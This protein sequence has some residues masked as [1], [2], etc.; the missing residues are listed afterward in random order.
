MKRKSL[1]LAILFFVVILLAIA[2]AFH[3]YI[4]KHDYLVE[5]RVGCDPAIDSCF[6]G[7]CDP[8]MGERCS[9]DRDGASEYSYAVVQRNA[10]YLPACGLNA[11]DCPITACQVGETECEMRYCTEEDVQAGTACST[12]ETAT[13]D[14]GTMDEAP[15]AEEPSSVSASE[16]DSAPDEGKTSGESP[17]QTN[18]DYQ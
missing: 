8:D 16:G 3:R 7:V 17:S 5:M 11:E 13:A 15:A 4:T 18:T 10:Q 12:P 6:V 2:S 14:R 9:E 1:V